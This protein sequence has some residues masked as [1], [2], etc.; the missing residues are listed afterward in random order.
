MKRQRQARPM[1]QAL[2]RETQRPSG[3]VAEEAFD[4]GSHVVGVVCAR[5]PGRT[6]V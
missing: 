1:A 3:R 6:G 5:D 4:A 2:R